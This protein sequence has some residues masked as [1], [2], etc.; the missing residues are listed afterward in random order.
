MWYLTVFV[1]SS[2]A[3]F[4]LRFLR[5]KISMRESHQALAL[6]LAWLAIQLSN[7]ARPSNNTVL[8]GWL[9]IYGF[10]SLVLLYG[11]MDKDDESNGGA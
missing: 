1:F 2:V 8:A 3:P 6:S 5:D 11:R 9:F 7:P 4:C 10:G